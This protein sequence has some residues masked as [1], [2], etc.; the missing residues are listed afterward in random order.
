MFQ[1]THL[2]EIITSNKNS[3]SVYLIDLLKISKF[4]AN[5]IVYVL[6][7][8]LAVIICKEI[9]FTNNYYT[10]MLRLTLLHFKEFFESIFSMQYFCK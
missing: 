10:E 5:I 2:L 7:Q 9:R 4:S 3:K 8:I 6:K 1:I